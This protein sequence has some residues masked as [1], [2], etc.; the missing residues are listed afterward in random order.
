ML[1]FLGQSDA[2]ATVGGD[3]H[4]WNPLWS[5]HFRSSLKTQ[6]WRSKDSIFILIFIHKGSYGLCF[7]S[8]IFPCT[9][10]KIKWS[11]HENGYS[12]APWLHSAKNGKSFPPTYVAQGSI[13][14][15]CACHIRVEFIVG[16][17]PTPGVFLRVLWFS[18]G[19]SGFPPF[20]NTN[21]SKFQ[22]DQ[23]TGLAWKPAK[24]AVAS[25]L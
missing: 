7:F 17:R 12:K 18:S 3:I 4:K 13:P 1:H 16:S 21:I 5:C 6:W 9:T 22:F 20:T 2:R 19:F 23:D 24:A 10:I 15:R 25:S 11:I 8:S 14:V